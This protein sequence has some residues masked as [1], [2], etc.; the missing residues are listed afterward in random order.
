[1]RVVLVFSILAS[2]AVPAQAS[3]EFDFSMKSK[4]VAASSAS[5]PARNAQAP[6]RIARDPLPELM[7]LEEQERRGPSGACQ[8]AATSVCYDVAEGKIVYRGARQYMPKIDGLRPE[9]MSLRRGRL[10]LKYS[11]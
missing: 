7:M 5:V 4:S 3:D 2:L 9:S 1:M 8:H 6:F 11:F 10:T